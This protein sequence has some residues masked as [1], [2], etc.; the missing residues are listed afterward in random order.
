[1]PRRRVEQV[2]AAHDLLDA[3]GGVVDHDRQ[4]VGDRPVVAA[5]HEV[6]DHALDVAVQAVDESDA[7]TAGAYPQGRRSRRPPRLQL[8]LCEPQAGAG[9]VAFR[10]RAVRRRR[11][12]P[13]LGPRAEALVEAAAGAQLLDGRGIA[14]PACR[15]VRHPG[16]PVDPDRGEVGQLLLGDALPDA[17]RVEVLHAHEEAA[18][19]RAGEQPGQQ[20]GPQVAEVERARR[21]GREAALHTENGSEPAISANRGAVRSR[22]E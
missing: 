8:G 13:D 19:R 21:A 11:C 6:V 5:H 3:L 4:V 20:R 2:V 12:L 15:L 16:V 14:V 7:L 9:I 17:A 18:A 1:M 22:S 10:Q